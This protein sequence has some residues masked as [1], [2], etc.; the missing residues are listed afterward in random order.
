MS[1]FDTVSKPKHYHA[2][3]R[4]DEDGRAYYEPVKVIARRLTPLSIYWGC[5]FNV[6]KYLMR[7]SNKGAFGE[8]IKKAIWYIR[9]MSTVAD[10]LPEHLWGKEN[11]EEAIQHIKEAAD[12]F[13][14][15]PRIK[16][17]LVFFEQR[18]FDWA[19]TLLEE[20]E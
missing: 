10:E 15:D 1:E 14:L 5:Y 9:K 3:K 20:I 17:A 7:C 12:D 13:D 11:Q 16:E 6:I 2:G 8:D 18:C 4:M 19:I